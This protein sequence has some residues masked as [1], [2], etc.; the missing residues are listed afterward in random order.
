MLYYILRYCSTPE[1]S[2][3][4]ASKSRQAPSPSVESER[5]V[6]VQFK[7]ERHSGKQVIVGIALALIAGIATPGMVPMVMIGSAALTFLYAYGGIAPFLVCALL[8]ILT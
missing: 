1:A 7:A 2:L 4:S 5:I 8:Q 3:R 6:C